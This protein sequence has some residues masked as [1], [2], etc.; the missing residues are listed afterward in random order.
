MK[1]LNANGTISKKILDLKDELHL[2]DIFKSSIATDKDK[3]CYLTD[4]QN[5]RLN[6]ILDDEEYER[7]FIFIIESD[8]LVFEEEFNIDI[9]DIADIS[10]IQELKELIR[11]GK[12]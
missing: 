11:K 2:K 10:T 5:D 8:K 9:K 7:Y 12:G 6:I 3:E 4:S 1:I